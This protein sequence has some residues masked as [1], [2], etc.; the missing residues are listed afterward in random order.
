MR[1]RGVAVEAMDSTAAAATFNFLNF[2]DRPVAAAL[3]A[4]AELDPLTKG[5]RARRG[6]GEG[7]AHIPVVRAD[8]ERR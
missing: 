1:A 5:T 6:G 4:V 3:L 2:E 8:D 7:G